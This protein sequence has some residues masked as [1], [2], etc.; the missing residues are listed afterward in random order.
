MQ[1]IVQLIERQYLK[2]DTRLGF[3]LLLLSLFLSLSLSLSLSLLKT[4]TNRSVRNHSEPSSKKPQSVQVTVTEL[5]N[6]RTAKETAVKRNAWQLVLF[7]LSQTSSLALSLAAHCV[8]SL[9]LSLAA[10]RQCVFTS[11]VPCSTPSVCLH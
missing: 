8:S 9:A 5:F 10:H 4:H 7:L 1:N 3:L 11:P 2:I 6:D